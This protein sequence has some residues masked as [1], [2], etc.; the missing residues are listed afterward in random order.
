MRDTALNQNLIYLEGHQPIY[1]VVINRA[2]GA[3]R[4]SGVDGQLKI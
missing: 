4:W 3:D 1:M 2:T